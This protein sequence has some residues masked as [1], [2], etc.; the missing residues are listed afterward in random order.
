ML[1]FPVQHLLFTYKPIYLSSF[2]LLPL[3]SS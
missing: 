1:N 3:L 2:Y